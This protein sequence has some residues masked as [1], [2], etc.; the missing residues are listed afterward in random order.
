MSVDREKIIQQLESIADADF[1]YASAD[2]LIAEWSARGAAADIVEPILLFVEAHAE[3]D[4]GGPGSIVHYLETFSGSGYE[5]QLVASLKRKPTP[6]TVLMLNRWINGARSKEER[7]QLLAFLAD[8]KMHPL[9]DDATRKEAT[10]F[11]DYQAR[12]DG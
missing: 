3:L 6:L 8:A 9:A 12:K 7:A 1:F 2:K 4:Y 11:E 5:E 10:D